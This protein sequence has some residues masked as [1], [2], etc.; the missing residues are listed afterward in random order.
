MIVAIDPG[1][2]G[3]VV[4]LSRP[5]ESRGWRLPY[6]GNRVALERLLALLP[7]TE[8]TSLVV[9]EILG[10]RRKQSVQSCATQ[11]I[12]WGMIV[13]ALRGLGYLVMTVRPQEWKAVVLADTE[14][15]KE[16]AI[17]FCQI[18]Y[19]EIDLIPGRCKKP[20]DGIADAACIGHWAILEKC[21][22]NK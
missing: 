18:N 21:A 1:L 12:N 17:K 5:G 11:S 2:E 4:V 22:T 19:P 3:G 14:K 10:F 8:K 9:I 16:D 6:D 13:G 7:P 20:Q 15:E